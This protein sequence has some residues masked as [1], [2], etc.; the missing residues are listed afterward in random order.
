MQRSVLSREIA[1]EAVIWGIGN[2]PTVALLNA[3]GAKAI[4]ADVMRVD[5]RGSLAI[6]HRVICRCSFR[7]A[8]RKV[9]VGWGRWDS[10]PHA[11]EAAD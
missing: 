5:P 2:E 11:S 7:L 8:G 6:C 10:N 1:D 9:K 4:E 3:A